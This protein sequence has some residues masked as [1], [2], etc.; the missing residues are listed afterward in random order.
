MIRVRP[1]GVT[2]TLGSATRQWAQSQG[3]T[4]LRLD[5]LDTLGGCATAVQA[6]LLTPHALVLVGLLAGSWVASLQ[7]GQWAPRRPSARDVARGLGGGVLLGWGAMT[8]LGCTIGTLLSGT[9][10]GA[11]SG[12]VFG[13]ALFMAVALGLRGKAWWLRRPGRS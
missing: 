5:G 6:T 4:P 13:I 7:S 12:W 11:L 9:M 1:L 10:A 3:W 8:G 2:A